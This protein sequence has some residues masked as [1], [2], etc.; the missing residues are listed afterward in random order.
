M[1][2]VVLAIGGATTYFLVMAQAVRNQ[3]L[4]ERQFNAQVEQTVED[5]RRRI[6]GYEFG[7]R[8]ARG[9]ITAVGLL[10]HQHN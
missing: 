4:I 8:G 7:L 10:I 6:I 2:L 5:V 9:A 3:E 1:P